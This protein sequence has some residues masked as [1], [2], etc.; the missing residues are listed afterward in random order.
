MTSDEIDYIRNVGRWFYGH[1]PA[2]VSN[3][4]GEVVA[5][6]VYKVVEGSRMMHLVP[7]PTGSVPGIGWL[8]S[9]AVQAWWRSHHE[10]RVYVAVK[11]A[12]ALGYKSTYTMAELGV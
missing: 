8:I 4:L 11:N 12:V 5:E 3:E 6:M 10:E 7:R 1:P 9:Q 2:N